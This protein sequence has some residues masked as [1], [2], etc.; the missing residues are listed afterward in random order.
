MD[1]EN[2]ITLYSMQLTNLRQLLEA[3]REKRAALISAKHELF[4]MA[5]R[6]EEKLLGIVQNIERQRSVL[7]ADLLKKE[8]PQLVDRSIKRLSVLLK[9]KLSAKEHEA[10]TDLENE[11]KKTIEELNGENSHNLF[12][13]HHLRNFYSE[14]MHALVGKSPTAIVDRKV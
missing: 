10:L 1:I 2:I 6:K 12:L 11:M 8:L 3:A 13:L 14:T 9:G 7:V 5:A 4:E